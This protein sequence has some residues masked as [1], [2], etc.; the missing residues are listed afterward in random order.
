MPARHPDAGRP[1][2]AGRLAALAAAAATLLPALSAPA[3]AQVSPGPLARPHASIDSTLKCFSC[4][5]SSKESMDD[6]CLA[7]HEDIG[8]LRDR[9]RGF[10]GQAGLPACSSCHPDHG[11]RDFELIQ[12]KEGAPEKFD[13]VRSGWPLKGRHAELRCASCHQAKF[14]L[15]AAAKLGRHDPG[16]QRWTG[17]ETACASCHEDAHRGALGPDCASCHGLQHWKPAVGFDH[18]KTSFPLTG[19]HA[20]VACAACHQA[21]HLK[22]KLDGAGRPIPLYKPLPHAECSSCH[23]DVHDARLG[24]VC[25][26]CHGT[27]DFHRVAKES[28]DHDRTRYPLRGAHRAVKC[29]SCHEAAAA[30]G[31]QPAFA[32]CGDCHADAHAGKATLAGKAVD[33]ASCHEV[34]GWRTSTFTVAQHASTPYPLVGA[35]ARVAC[36]SC[37]ARK[38][39]AAGL[40]SSGVVIRAAHALCT[41]CHADAHAG[42]LASAKDGG[43]CESCHAVAGWKPS[44]FTAARHDKLKF[45]LKGRHAAIDCAACHGP[46]RPGLPPVAPAKQVGSAR[47]EL[48]L[49]VSDCADCHRDPHAGRFAKSATSRCGDCHTSAVSWT[50]TIDVEGHRRFPF[51]LGGA[52]RAVPCIACHKEMEGPPGGSTLKLASNPGRP[53]PFR[54]GRTRCSDCHEDPHGDQFAK[55][56][57][58]DTCDTCH[59]DNRFKPAALFDHEHDT[60]F[61]LK[62]AHARVTCGECHKPRIDEKGVRRVVYRSV[63]TRCEDCH[64]GGKQGGASP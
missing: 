14:Q 15:S 64:A 33:C 58:G 8:W 27:D 43:A 23:K 56:K 18:A 32:R 7:C 25:S 40:G 11:G 34:S 9:H 4:H 24:P 47:V 29:A 12:W 30:K 53:L 28:F 20:P 63:P 2:R 61:P 41:D 10:H 19:K 59:V 49:R 31:R 42:Q 37:H 52:H 6:K 55:R 17:L 46:L 1:R 45:P 5:G 16:S 21:K 39:G 13:H 44:T 60:V 48:A 54:A 51:P 57:G 26:K 50:S 35:H 36:A 22:L 38:K 62:G 3:R